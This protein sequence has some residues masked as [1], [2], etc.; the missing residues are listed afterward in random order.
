MIMIMLIRMCTKNHDIT[1]NDP[2]EI[3]YINFENLLIKEHRCKNNTY[4]MYYD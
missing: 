3:I 2:F 1:I 4:M